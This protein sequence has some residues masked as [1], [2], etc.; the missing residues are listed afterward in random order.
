MSQDFTPIA[1]FYFTTLTTAQSA[2]VPAT[3][4]AALGAGSKVKVKVF[5]LGSDAIIDFTD[6]AVTTIASNVV[7]AGG[8][9]CL[10]GQTLEYTDKLPTTISVIARTGTVTGLNIQLGV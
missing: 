1:N 5:C 10:A 7:L 8:V 2:T 4:L 3:V 6:T 9:L